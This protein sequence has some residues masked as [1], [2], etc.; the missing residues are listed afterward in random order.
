MMHR[1]S[2]AMALV[3]VT[4]AFALPPQT[5][6]AQTTTDST[7]T[8]G[9]HGSGGSGGNGNQGQGGHGNG[10]SGGHGGNDAIVSPA[11]DRADGPLSNNPAPKGSPANPGTYIRFD[12]GYLNGS[13]GDAFWQPP[14][15]PSDPEV[16]FDVSGD[17]GLVGGVAVGRYVTP[18]IRAEGAIVLFGD[19]PFDG[20]WSYTIPATSGPHADV[21]GSVRSVALMA[22][23]YY[24]FP[25]G[26][27]AITPYVTAGIGLASNTMSD[28]TR[29]N[30]DVGR[31]E[32]TFAGGQNSDLAWSVGVGASVDISRQ[33]GR[34]ALLDFGYRYY[35]L[36]QAVGSTTPLPGS[37]SGGDPVTGLTID[38]QRQVFNIGITFPM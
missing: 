21:R 25:T 13:F 12:L 33:V 4:A 34:A 22:N 14:G 16:H 17:S 11:G 35:D 8:D 29:I 24:D 1:L 30:A 23:G 10:G 31:T 28:W 20:S 7:H 27:G 9:D 6:L 3:L 37:G 15:F 5:A 18:D 36:G 32:R 19:Q 2:T 38:V 26:A